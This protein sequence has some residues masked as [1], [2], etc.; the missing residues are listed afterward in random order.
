MKKV[1]LAIIAVMIFLTFA[2]CSAKSSGNSESSGKNGTESIRE[3]ESVKGSESI[4]E[5]ESLE[6]R[7]VTITFVQE[8]EANITKTIKAGGALSAAEIPTP[9]QKRGYNVSWNVTDFS[10]MK[11]DLT[12]IAVATAKK[13]AIV[14]KDKNGTELNSPIDVMFDSPYSLPEA[15]LDEYRFLGWSY[16]DE[17]IE[18]SGI[19]SIDGETRIEIVAIWGDPNWTDNF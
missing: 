15:D 13:Y 3:G 7:E 10:S 16:K 9:A 12:V 18:N 1:I 14:F 19:W 4:K 17:K 6:D 2:A 11:S 5:N 8:G